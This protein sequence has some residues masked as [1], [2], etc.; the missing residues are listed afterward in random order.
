[1]VATVDGEEGVSMG[2]DLK[3]RD[4]SINAG[5]AR[6]TDRQTEEFGKGWTQPPG[7]VLTS[8]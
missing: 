6:Q 8:E 2:L 4:K 7:K 1:M 3:S 5:D